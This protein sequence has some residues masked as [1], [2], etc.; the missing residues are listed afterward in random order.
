MYTVSGA[1][2]SLQDGEFDSEYYVC[3]LQID[4]L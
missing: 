3:S 1:R 2:D 4:M